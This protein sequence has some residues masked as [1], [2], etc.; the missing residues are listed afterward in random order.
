MEAVPVVK[1]ENPVD[2]AEAKYLLLEQVRSLCRNATPVLWATSVN[3]TLLAFV[4]RN[5][6]PRNYLLAW[7]IAVYLTVG[8]RD[9]LLGRCRLDAMAPHE[10]GDWK[11]QFIILTALS[12]MLWGVTSLF[13][14]PDR[15]IA[16][17]AFLA[18]V[19]GGMAA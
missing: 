6:I 16:H 17:Q 2:N 15:S 5:V 19:L 12:G 18:F 1:R 14:F 10:I 7:L 4:L 8:L 9:F 3:A 13:L 11:R